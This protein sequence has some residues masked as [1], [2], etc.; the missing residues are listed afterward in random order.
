MLIMTPYC[1]K[2]GLVE[3]L[4]VNVS[5]SYAALPTVLLTALPTVLLTLR[6]LQHR[7]WEGGFD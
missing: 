6:S 5:I 2:E 1:G 3:Y 7:L 4:D